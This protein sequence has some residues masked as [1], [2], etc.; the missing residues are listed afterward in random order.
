MDG[1][2][3]IRTDVRTPPDWIRLVFF[4]KP[5]LKTILHSSLQQ[6]AKTHFLFNEYSYKI[7]HNL[8]LKIYPRNGRQT[9]IQLLVKF[10]RPPTRCKGSSLSFYDIETG[11]LRDVVA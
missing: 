11:F 2:T 7:F 6:E 9:L 5:N 3:H 4:Q 10:G 1:H 8:A